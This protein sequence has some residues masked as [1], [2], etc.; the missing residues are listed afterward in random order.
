MGVGPVS[1]EN[2]AWNANTEADLA[3][4]KM[5]RAPGACTNPGAFATVATFG[6]V[7]TGSNTPTAD[8]TYCY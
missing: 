6:K 5:Y 4:Y 8:A 3:G 2:F 7:T 1:A